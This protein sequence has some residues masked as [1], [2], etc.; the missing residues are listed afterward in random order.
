MIDVETFRFVCQ[1]VLPLV[2][3]DSLSY[4]EVLCKVSSKL[5]EVIGGLN[6]NNDNVREL[7]AYV[8]E[9]KKLI[10]DIG[11]SGVATYDKKGL[12]QIDANT[13]NVDENGLISVRTAVGD[14]KGIVSADGESISVMNG[15]LSAVVGNANRKGILQVDGSSIV[16]DNGVIRV[17]DG[18]KDRKG[19]FKIDGE[20]LVVEGGVLK[21]V[22][23]GV[24]I[25][26]NEVVGIVKVDGRTIVV[27]ED[28]TIKA[29]G[30]GTEEHYVVNTSNGYALQLSVE[31][32]GEFEGGYTVSVLDAGGLPHNLIRVSDTQCTVDGVNVDYT[33]EHIEASGYNLPVATET[34]LGGVK[35][36]YNLNA[37][38]EGI[39]T[40]N[41]DIV[42]GK[43]LEHTMENDETEFSIDDGSINDNSWIRIGTSEY[44]V[45]PLMV[46]QNGHSITITFEEPH[47]DLVVK[48]VVR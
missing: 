6:E 2:Y 10:E 35:V 45:N 18:S 44:G 22:R 14:S 24:P 30:A 43:I 31:D 20:T 8:N 28:G 15:V 26:T 9:V 5:N 37:N 48:V 1:K 16:E 4:Y 47:N 7:E 41:E 13:L 12:V 42:Y 27:D 33:V 38:N 21:V 40:V 29:T 17:P 39:I 19:I 25:A 34:I 3:D 36:G 23:E 32:Y 46:T 11:L